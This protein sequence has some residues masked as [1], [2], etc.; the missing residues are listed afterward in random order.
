MIFLQEHHTASRPDAFPLSTAQQGLW[1]AELLAPASN[2][3]VTGQYSEIA[4]P[5]D[6]PL[7][8]AASRQVLIE[9]E[10]L[11]LCF[12]GALD[13]PL[14]WV[15]PLG[16]WSLPLLDFSARPDPRAAALAWM[17]EQL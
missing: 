16:D 4:G 5:V 14:Q 3:N 12:G 9:T 6:V 8:E 1:A 2:A 7:F 17:H 13:E 15:Q 11:R 10:A